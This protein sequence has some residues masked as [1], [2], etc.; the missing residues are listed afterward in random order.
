MPCLGPA[1][2]STSLLS[3][4]GVRISSP[5]RS[6]HCS[7][8]FPEAPPRSAGTMGWGG[9]RCGL[10]QQRARD[11][12]TD[13]KAGRTLLRGGGCADPCLSFPA[14]LGSLQSRALLLLEAFSL[15]PRALI[16]SAL[17]GLPSRAP[18]SKPPGY[19]PIPQL[20]LLRL[21]RSW[22]AAPPCAQ[23]SPLGDPQ[24][25]PAR[26]LYWRSPGL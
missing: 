14:V 12:A 1:W 9:G 5:Q 22:D 10:E 7:A 3:K 2:T 8:E 11:T 13:P 16:S 20:L 15:M 23:L 24:S 21:C 18:G 25:W 6:H 4:S 17:R 26:L 19:A